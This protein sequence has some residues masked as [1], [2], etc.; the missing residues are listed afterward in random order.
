MG[1]GLQLLLGAACLFAALASATAVLLTDDGSSAAAPG[2]GGIT[3]L[4]ERASAA[5]E[6]TLVRR[7][8]DGAL[9]RMLEQAA[10][11]LRP[12]EFV[13][14]TVVVAAGAGL[15]GAL[16]G[17]AGISFL[18][19]IMATLSA[20]VFVAQ[21]RGRR[22][23]IFATQLTELLPTL[24][25]SLRAG[26]GLVQAVEAAGREF[27]GPVGAELRRVSTEVRLG[28]DLVDALRSLAERMENED[29]SW[30]VS[31][32]EI[33]REV[34]GDLAHILDRVGHTI[35]ARDHIRGQ[36]R[37]ASAEGR[38]SGTVLACLPPALLAFQ[39]VVNPAYLSTFVGT[40]TGRML[41]IVCAVLLGIG[42]LWIRRI[43]RVET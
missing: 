21:R 38:V 42:T 34:G 27:E 35:R 7:G 11:D 15:V 5:A 41:L 29:F 22:R 23:A 36:V 13:L 25:A 18:F 10:L 28:R 26:H 31:A 30:V 20:Y 16:L 6:R 3:G 14:A 2:P 39:A 24:A 8:W 19:L 37:S 4:A 9:D 32:V 1:G 33:H 43:A 40:S 12:G 17:G